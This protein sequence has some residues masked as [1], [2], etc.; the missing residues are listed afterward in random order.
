MPDRAR[1]GPGDTVLIIGAGGGV[2]IHG[3][4]M[5]KLCGGW[6]RSA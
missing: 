2:G 5:A 4:Q 3:V 6:R 1:V